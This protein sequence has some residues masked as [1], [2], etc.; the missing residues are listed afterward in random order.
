M[1]P[2]E[3][4]R[5]QSLLDEWQTPVR[6]SAEFELQLR[7]RLRQ[8][9]GRRRRVRS[10]WGVAG[11]AAAAAVLAV[12]VNVGQLAPPPAAKTV[13]QMAVVQDLQ[14]LNGNAEVIEHLDFLSPQVELPVNTEQEQD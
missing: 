6:A 11:A 2:S 8:R 3:Q 9:E 14:L 7:Q 13:E 5:L 10:W 12:F 4:E 1:T